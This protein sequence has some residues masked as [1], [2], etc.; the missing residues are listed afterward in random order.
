MDDVS[1]EQLLTENQITPA[2]MD[3][4]DMGVQ[5]QRRTRDD[6]N[7]GNDD[8]PTLLVQHRTNRNKQ[9]KSNY[10]KKFAPRLKPLQEHQKAKKRGAPRGPIRL[11]LAEWIYP[12]S[13][14]K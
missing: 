14:T 7:E 5:G 13:S 8:S 2:D 12:I 4:T 1:P 11:L 9:V 10:R 6:R 3:L